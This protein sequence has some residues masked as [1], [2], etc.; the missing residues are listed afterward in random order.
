MIG[1][2]RKGGKHVRGKRE[3]RGRGIGERRWLA[4]GMG[5]APC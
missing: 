5:C 1:A 3:R 2:M 4:E